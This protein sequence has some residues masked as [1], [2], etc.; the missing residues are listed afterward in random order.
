MACTAFET[1]AYRFCHLC[2]SVLS[3]QDSPSKKG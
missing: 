2:K 1:A 3:V